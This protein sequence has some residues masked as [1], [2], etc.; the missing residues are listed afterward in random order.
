MLFNEVIE[1]MNLFTLSAVRTSDLAISARK[2]MNWD[3]EAW[4]TAPFLSTA[5]NRPDLDKDLLPLVHALSK[6]L[7]VTISLI[8]KEPEPSDIS[9]NGGVYFGQENEFIPVE[10]IIGTQIIL[11]N[12][13]LLEAYEFDLYRKTLNEK[14]ERFL[15]EKVSLKD[16]ISRG[17]DT[18]ISGILER[19]QNRYER[20]GVRKRVGLWSNLGIDSIPEKWIVAYEEISNR[21]N[22]LTHEAHPDDVTLV[23][24][25]IIFHRTRLIARQ[26]A[27][28][29]N[30]DSVSL[31]QSPLDDYSEI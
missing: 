7:S 27:N 31:C 21:R 16:V 4:S 9:E 14:Q 11:Y 6:E 12:Y 20:M 3:E 25:I 30:D 24:A 8:F 26:L 29:F 2:M 28:H 23:E 5:A 10:H 18:L 15:D 1:R 17:T 22:T 13:C 19:E